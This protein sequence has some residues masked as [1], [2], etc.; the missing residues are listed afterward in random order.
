LTSFVERGQQFDTPRWLHDMAAGDD[1]GGEESREHVPDTASTPN[2]VRI[3]LR[4]PIIVRDA[5]FGVL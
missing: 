5:D 1:E 4:V 3:L 2:G